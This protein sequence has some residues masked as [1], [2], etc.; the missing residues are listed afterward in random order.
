MF[1]GFPKLRFDNPRT[2]LAKGGVPPLDTPDP[3]SFKKFLANALR[4]LGV[5]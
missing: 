5:V 1:F 4:F 3:S 2:L